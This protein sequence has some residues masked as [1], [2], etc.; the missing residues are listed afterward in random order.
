MSEN[1]IYLCFLLYSEQNGFVSPVLCL[2]M[3]EKQY[4]N[5]VNDNAYAWTLCQDL[6]HACG[7]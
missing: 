4:P 7:K 6:K 1:N 5:K 2:L 3:F